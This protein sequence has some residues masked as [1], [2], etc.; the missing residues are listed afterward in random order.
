MEGGNEKIEADVTT[1][2]DDNLIWIES[3][4]IMEDRSE[5]DLKH[6]TN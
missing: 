5:H 2:H 4:Q 3:D 6:V 1:E